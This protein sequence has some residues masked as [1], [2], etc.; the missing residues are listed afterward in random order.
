[1]G[2][3]GLTNSFYHHRGHHLKRP[4]KVLKHCGL[5]TSVRFSEKCILRGLKVLFR[6]NEYI[7]IVTKGE[8]F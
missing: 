2:M 7:H 8:Y 6:F 5:L 4:L 1:M 3:Y